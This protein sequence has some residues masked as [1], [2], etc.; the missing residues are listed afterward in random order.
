M[1]P[2]SQSYSFEKDIHA[3]VSQVYQAFTNSSLVRQW[4]SDVAIMNA[5]LGGYIFLAWNSGFYA[6][7][8]FT[9]MVPNKKLT[10][11]WSGRNEPGPTKVEVNL[12]TKGDNTQVQ[13][14]HSGIGPGEE[15]DTMVTEL[16]EGWTSGLENLASVLEKGE[17]LRFTHRPML[18]IGLNDF[19]AEIAQQLGVPV[20]EGVRID[21]TLEGMGAQAAGLQPN[22]VI[23]SLGGYQIQQFADLTTVM[24]RHRAGDQVEVQFYRG[25]EKK[26]VTMTLSGRPMPKLA[27][28]IH[29]LA[30]QVRSRFVKIKQ[31]FDNFLENVSQEEAA[32]QPA[33]GEWSIM[34]ILAHLIRDERGLQNYVLEIVG[35]REGHYDEYTG[36]Q[37]FGNL[38]LE[39]AYPTLPELGEALR[40]TYDETVGLYANLPESVLSQKSSFWRLAYGILESPFHYQAHLEQMQAVLQGARER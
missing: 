21:N 6:S 39:A 3:P 15:W 18:G 31:D 17:D 29:E 1:S 20:S 25:P 28:S 5:R 35:G 37:Q 26:A 38:A 24:Q 34:D 19:N 7:G 32:Y 16:R 8:E 27:I 14:I 22:D 2:N 11:T 33:P 30:D 12:F 36:N 23:V 4:L 13:L 9:E 10:F 40:H